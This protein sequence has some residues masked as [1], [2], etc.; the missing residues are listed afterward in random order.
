MGLAMTLRKSKPTFDLA[1]ESRMPAPTMGRRAVRTSALIQE[2][3]REVFLQKG[4][5]G[6]NIEDIAEAAGISR[7]QRLIKLPT[8][9]ITS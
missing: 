5:H 2:T 9:C 6:T 4:Y 7:A 8:R 1:G 3:A